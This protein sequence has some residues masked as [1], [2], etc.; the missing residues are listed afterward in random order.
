MSEI[1]QTAAGALRTGYGTKPLLH[2]RDGLRLR[3]GLLVMSVDA[4]EPRLGQVEAIYRDGTIG[5]RWFEVAEAVRQPA[6]GIA[7]VP[8]HRD[9]VAATDV[10][11]VD[12]QRGEIRS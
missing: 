10:L 5:V 4:S 12:T 9:R 11:L 6:D 3:S 2:R 8:M 1:I 7:H